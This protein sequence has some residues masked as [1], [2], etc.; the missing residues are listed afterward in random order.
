MR[1]DY[2]DIAIE[3]LRYLQHSMS[4]P[5]Y[6]QIVVQS[7]QIAEKLLKSVV[8]KVCLDNLEELLKTHNLKKILSAINVEEEFLK[9]VELEMGYLK[10]F[11]FEAKYPGENFMVVTPVQCE[12]CLNIMYNILDEVNRFRESI[13]E[14]T[15][16][17]KRVFVTLREEN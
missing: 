1:N 14:P 8:E 12:R 17:F 5:G 15:S 9:L 3:D 13:D 11:Y 2:Y 10:D 16:A 4:Y 6:N 7:Q